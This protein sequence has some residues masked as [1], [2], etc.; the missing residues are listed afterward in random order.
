[1]ENFS[2]LVLNMV[3]RKKAYGYVMG[4][5]LR[6][7]GI[8]L[9]HQGIYKALGVLL[10]KG[11]I[12]VANEPQE[13][14]PDRKIYGITPEGV[15]ILKTSLP[16]NRR[17]AISPFDLAVLTNKLM[18]IVAALE[19]EHKSLLVAEALPVESPQKEEYVQWLHGAISDRIS[20]LTKLKNKQIGSSNADPHPTN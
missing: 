1:M 9:S 12:H 20:L 7:N 19:I 2:I 4:K 13:G 16:N 18:Y 15:E 17:D 5:E 6:D 10:K 11:F 3:E 14:K 8:S